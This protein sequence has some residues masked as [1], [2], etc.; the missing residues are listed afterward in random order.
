[1]DLRDHREHILTYGEGNEDRM[2]EEKATA[3][4]DEFSFGMDMCQNNSW[5]FYRTLCIKLC[6][7]VQK[8]LIKNQQLM[9]YKME[10][11]KFIQ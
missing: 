10:I 8:R 11:D 2:T 1:M 9:F 7:L 3:R 4:I 6:I 5:T